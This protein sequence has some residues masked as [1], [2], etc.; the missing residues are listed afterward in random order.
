MSSTVWSL[1]DSEWDPDAGGPLMHRR[2]LSLQETLSTAPLG[3][4]SRAAGALRLA[5]RLAPAAK[6]VAN[7]KAHV[8]ATALA[9]RCESFDR[10]RQD[11]CILML[12][13]LN[14]GNPFSTE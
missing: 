12:P 14:L 9:A 3:D 8:D 4:S 5:E 2:L 1:L 10:A 7:S 6:K 11:V 13:R